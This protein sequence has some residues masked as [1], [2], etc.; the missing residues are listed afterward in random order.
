MRIVLAKLRNV[1]SA[2]ILQAAGVSYTRDYVLRFGFSPTE[3]SPY[4]SMVLGVGSMAPLKMANAYAVFANGGYRVI[5][6][7]VSRIVD[8]DG[9]VL[10]EDERTQRAA[11]E[12]RVIDP[13]N[14]FLMTS[15]MQDVVKR[16]TAA[17][18]AQLGRADIAGK[19]GTTTISPMPGSLA[20]LS[21]WWPSLGWASIA[22]GRLGV[23]KLGRGP[24]CRSG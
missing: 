5:P 11:G 22:H 4:L 14:A 18:A 21:I 1:A 9:E 15:M 12:Q 20:T 6:Y 2:R 10:L 19:T 8:A 16:G 13:R 24:R 23:T 3:V 7:L 17:Q